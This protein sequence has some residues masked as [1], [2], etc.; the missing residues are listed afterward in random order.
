MRLNIDLLLSVHY[1][2]GTSK[3]GVVPSNCSKV[4]SPSQ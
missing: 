2:R 1:E 3:L 4:A